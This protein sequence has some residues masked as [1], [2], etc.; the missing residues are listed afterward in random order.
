[1]MNRGSKINSPDVKP[2]NCILCGENR[3]RA[4][5][6]KNDWTYLRCLSCGLVSISPKPSPDEVLDSYREYLPRQAEQIEDWAKTMAPVIARSV[7]LIKVRMNGKAG[8]LLDIGSGYGFF[9]SAMQLEGWEVEGIEISATGR[10]YGEKKWGMKIHSSPLEELNL[11]EKSYDAVTLFYV[12]EHIPDPMAIIKRARGILKPGGLLLVRWPHT[13]PLIKMMGSF[14]K[15]LDLYH[16][17]YHLYDFSHR[18]M[19][20]LL[21]QCGFS[22]VETLIGGHTL[23]R[24]KAARLSSI[25]AGNLGEILS[26]V[27]KGRILLP[28]LSK[29]TIARKESRS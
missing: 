2:A 3:F 10:D 23:P 15:G 20:R 7:N 28:G 24:G 26:T 21:T 6:R 4:I 19:K 25:V 9:L 8:K 11:P 13:T 18:T 1:M 12:I 14:S 17:P 27:S 29:T 5:H 22:N 16:T